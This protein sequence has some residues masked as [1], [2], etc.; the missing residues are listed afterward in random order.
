MKT[1]TTPRK[2]IG[3]DVLANPSAMNQ[4]FLDSGAFSQRTQ[5][6]K[7]FPHNPFLYYETDEFWKY[8][9]SYGKFVTKFGNAIDYYATVDV[10]YNPELSWK[11]LRYL[12]KE[13]GLKPVPVIHFGTGLEWVE[14][15]LDAGYDF[16]GLGGFGSKKSTKEKYLKWVGNIF[17]L[18]CPR[19]SR[20]P[21]VRFHGFAMTSW[22]ML[23]RFPWYSVDSSSWVQFAA[24]GW[25]CFPRK[26]GGTFNFKTPPFA[27][28][29]SE[30]AGT[31]SKQGKH[32]MTVNP[33][34]RAILKEW[35]DMNGVPLGDDNEKGVTNHYKYRCQANLLYYEALAAHL[36]P[37]PWP[38]RGYLTRTGFFDL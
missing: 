11:V 30:N 35:L 1:E 20:L 12:E 33:A 29:I 18:A 23:T 2:R 21:S 4:F 31:R 24:Y 10:I 9:R 16:I 15:H 37:W 26:T 13:F 14:K 36:P 3:F 8:V 6:K 22:E 32:Y 5:A 27:L 17:E 38:Y 25:V 7:E 19:P 28:Q 34:E